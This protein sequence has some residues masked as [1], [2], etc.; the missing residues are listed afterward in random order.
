[1]KVK[2][3]GRTTLTRREMMQRMSGTYENA[4]GGVGDLQLNG[5]SASEILD[6]REQ[7]RAERQAAKR[8]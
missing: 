2:A 5:R 4:F 7:L 3:D 6:E 1:M 8:S